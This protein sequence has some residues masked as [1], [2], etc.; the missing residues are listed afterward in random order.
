MGS[1]R[2]APQGELAKDISVALALLAVA[3]GLPALIAIVSG[4]L[5][6]AH[7]DDFAYRRVALRLYEAGRIELTGWSLMS[8][9][10][11]V[12]IVQPFLW[13]SAGASWAFAAATAVVCVAGVGAA[14]SM[15]RRLL[16]RPLATL[17]I[18]SLL[19]FP[20]FLVYTTSFMTDVPALAGEMVCLALGSVA[21]DRR[22]AGH[23]RWLAGS[24]I[25]GLFAFSIREF[26]L[27]APAAVL[28]AAGIGAPGRRVPYLVIGVVVLI[29][30]GAIHVI[31]TNLPGQGST[32][33]ELLPHSFELLRYAAATLGLVLSPALVLVVARWWR[34]WHL[35]D[36]FIGVLLGILV[37]KDEIERMLRT[38]TV[39]G[40]LI[41]NLLEPLGA[42]GG[43]AAGSR[44]ILFGP[45][46][47]DLL[48]AIGLIAII[49][50]F[51]VVSSTIGRWLRSGDLLDRGRLTA[52]LSSTQGML[53]L[54]VLL[55]GAGLVAYGF[56]APTY[57]RYLWPLAI[58]LTC[59]LL[60]RPMP[61]DLAS[62]APGIVRGSARGVAALLTATLA[63]TS[64][65]LLLNA[66][67]FDA[68][69]W[70]MGELAVRRGFTPG[71]VD[72]GM[73]WVGY[74]ATGIA[75]VGATPSATESWYDAWWPSF[76][77]CAMVSSSLLDI[78]GFRL[79]AA[80]IEAYRL[81]LFAGDEE[82]LYLYR[83]T[84]AGCP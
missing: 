83:V 3:V 23:W 26:A 41:G 70:R 33:L 25:A 72:A 5:T 59:L 56:V 22:D 15:V 79:E 40:V 73:A 60:L 8:L 11:Q 19:F 52:R 42:P 69:G 27:A 57:D 80:D 63:L 13:V 45:P 75:E 35:V 2:R 71:T 44:P 61:H 53:V 37:Y 51:G 49:A 47:W 39:P 28:F 66:F 34:H 6:V 74:Y 18:L 65:A 14:Y 1:S 48:N 36:G 16:P 84:G 68:A 21:I 7:N 38:G 29:A 30:S 24:L 20:G 55:Y 78:P 58:P 9:I 77:L 67:A 54:F 46:V 43:V 17:S 82:P 81:L 62:R 76:R 31:T 64:L 50:S 4:G 10:G 12:V 32:T